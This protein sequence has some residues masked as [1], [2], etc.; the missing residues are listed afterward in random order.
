MMVSLGVYVRRWQR[1]VRRWLLD[2][3]VHILAQ[4]V[5]YLLGGFVLSAASLGSRFM[6]LALGALC[7]ASGIPAVLL[8]AGSMV[9]YLVFWG[10][11]GAQ[12]VVWIMGGVL[13][14]TI[15]GGRP[16]LR[17]TLLMVPAL[18][19]FLV[20]A[21]G[22]GFQVWLGDQTPVSVYL[23]RIGLA[24]VSAGVFALAQRRKDPVV[25]WLVWGLVT[26]ALAQITITPY[27]GLGY[28]AAAALSCAGAFPA[29]ALAGLALDLSQ[30]TP[31]P[32]TA[33]MCLAYLV[34]LLPVGKKWVYYCAP[35]AVYLLVMYLCGYWDL[36]PLAG[37]LLGGL[38]AV[39]IP[40]RPELH[41]R[42]G[43]T[44]GAQVRLEMVSGVMRQAGELLKTMEDIPVDEQALINRAMERACGSCPYRKQCKGVQKEVSPALLHRP[45]GNGE[46]LPKSCRKK[47]RLLQEL[48]RS[49]EQLRAIRADRDRRLEYRYA[50]VQQYGFLSRYLQ[51]VSDSLAAR[52]HPPTPWYEPEVA[53]CSASRQRVNGD[54]CWCF[55]GV[56]CRYYILLC[57]GMG[58]GEAAAREGKKIGNMLRKLLTAGYPAAYALR[59][60]NSLCALQGRAGIVTV[61]LVEL[62]LDTGKASLYK[63]GAAPSYFISR[64]E[65]VKI[66]TATPPPG[67]SVTDCRETVEKLSL[68]RG[69]TLVLL[70]DGAGGEEA[71][72][73]SWEHALEP[74]EALAAKMLRAGAGENSDD[75][76]VA[77]IRLRA[78][79]V[80][81]P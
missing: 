59:T 34:R 78:A 42:R 60:A 52:K 7:A 37:L 26:L 14:A 66:G 77:V 24:M 73:T 11:S 43:E 46:S 72:R 71:V 62:H 38:V 27:V 51:E 29:A 4:G 65:S 64:G 16:L 70:S 45:L 56:E 58:T 17:G 15:L 63:W 35:G 22:L 28:A 3:R 68:R 74:V 61:D 69:E 1:V 23:L 5:G 21:V 79:P 40:G 12:G 39:W 2:T 44:G 54:R 48:R 25:Q 49:Q 6:P 30:I 75:A 31:V 10:V 47:G 20:S 36:M 57:D 9:G 53:V 33:V 67:L 19:G 41:H 13:A 80:D 50:V 55:A 8:A 81:L 76:T 18:A 32:M